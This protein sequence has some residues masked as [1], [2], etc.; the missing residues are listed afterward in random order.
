M[1]RLRVNS[2]DQMTSKIFSWTSFEIPF[3]SFEVAV[4][5]FY[6]TEWLENKFPR[7]RFFKSSFMFVGHMPSGIMCYRS[8]FKEVSFKK[9]VLMIYVLRKYV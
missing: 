6:H 9:Y 8:L 7:V 3:L 1:A 2:I 4:S 5:F